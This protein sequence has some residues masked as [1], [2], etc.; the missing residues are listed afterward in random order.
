VPDAT[1]HGAGEKADTTWVEPR[2]E[3]EITYSEITND[4]MVRQPSLKGLLRRR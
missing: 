3:A 4:G 1:A 2:F